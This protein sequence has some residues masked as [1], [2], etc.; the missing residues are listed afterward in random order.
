MA[1]EL[2]YQRYFAKIEDRTFKLPSVIPALPGAEDSYFSIRCVF[3]S[4][5]QPVWEITFSSAHYSI[6]SLG[7]QNTLGSLPLRQDAHVDTNTHIHTLTQT[8]RDTHIDT[9]EYAYELK[10][11]VLDEPD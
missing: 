4:P 7:L 8:H 5:G 11:R 1:V 9:N 6:F 3:K 10:N 2:I